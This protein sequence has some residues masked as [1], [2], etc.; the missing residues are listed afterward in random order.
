MIAVVAH[1]D[2][3]ARKIDLFS[4]SEEDQAAEC[5]G[6]RLRQGFSVTVVDAVDLRD[7]CSV[8]P[9]RWQTRAA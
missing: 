8:L 9:D 6:R 2:K 1:D 3:G 5:Y 4:G 7:L